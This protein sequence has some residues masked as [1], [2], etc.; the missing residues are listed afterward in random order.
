M[1]TINVTVEFILKVPDDVNVDADLFGVDIDVGR[2]Q[3]VDVDS[4]LIAGAS[5]ASY[6]TMFSNEQIG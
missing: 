4:N 1:R 5:V 2:I 3:V 6:E